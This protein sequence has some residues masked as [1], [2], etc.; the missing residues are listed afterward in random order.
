[1]IDAKISKLEKG[2]GASKS[3]IKGYLK[4]ARLLTVVTETDPDVIRTYIMVLS[5][6]AEKSLKALT[7]HVDRKAPARTHSLT[8]LYNNLSK[9]TQAELVMLAA[10]KPR[11]ILWALSD[12]KD[13][14]E[15]WR[16]VEEGQQETH[17]SR[18]DVMMSIMESALFR[19][20]VEL[21]RSLE[22]NPDT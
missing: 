21:K 17:F 20:D 4:T 10:A 5:F 12:N 13:S 8:T 9:K 1:M 6:G 2:I 19:L 7:R 15:E 14:F 11:H 18:P 16:Y 22:G 3:E